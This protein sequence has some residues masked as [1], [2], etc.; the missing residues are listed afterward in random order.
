MGPAHYRHSLGHLM[1]HCH[2][3]HSLEGDRE[4]KDGSA[5]RKRNIKISESNIIIPP[6]LIG[7]HSQKRSPSLFLQLYVLCT[8]INA[9]TFSSLSPMAT[10]LTGATFSWQ[11]GWLY[12]RGLGEGL[13]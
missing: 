3:S 8:G 2:H 13:L 10:S 1:S 4:H 9:G 6:L 5:N 12:L 11:I 7:G